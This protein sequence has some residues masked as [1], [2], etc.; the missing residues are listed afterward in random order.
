MG[1]NS[2]QPATILN[3]PDVSKPVGSSERDTARVTQPE[4][5]LNPLNKTAQQVSPSLCVC[6]CNCCLHFHALDLAPSATFLAGRPTGLLL[7]IATPRVR[8]VD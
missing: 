4:S 5:G 7:S 6:T 3:C 1:H 8:A 2:L